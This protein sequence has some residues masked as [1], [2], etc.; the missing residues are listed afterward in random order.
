[1]PDWRCRVASERVR[2]IDKWPNTV[3][4]GIFPQPIEGSLYDN[5]AWT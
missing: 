5:G 3:K 1:M 4:K 2:G